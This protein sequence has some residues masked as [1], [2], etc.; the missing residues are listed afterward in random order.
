MN[1]IVTQSSA[2]ALE[3][4]L[5]GGDLSKLSVPDRVMY[6]KKVCE[7]VGLNPLTKPFEYITLNNKLTL[8]ARRDAT[9]QL[10]QI[11]KVSINIV[12]RELVEDCYVVTARATTSI[13]QDESIG[14]VNIAGLK[15][16]ARANAMMKAETKAKRRVTLSICGLGMLDE[17]EVETIPGAQ[18]T[19]TAGVLASLPSKI[20]DVV[21]ETAEQIKAFLANDQTQDAYALWQNSHFDAEQETALWSLLPSNARSMLKRVD[22]AAKATE[23]GTISQAQHRR[24]EKYIKDNGIDREKVKEYAKTLFGKEHF[25]ELTKDEYARLDGDLDRFL[26]SKSAP[27]QDAT[28]PGDPQ[29]ALPPVPAAGAPDIAP[30][31]N[32]NGD[33][34]ARESTQAGA[35]TEDEEL[36]T[37]AAETRILE[38]EN[39]LDI[40]GSVIKA[41]F[42]GFMAKE[43]WKS[44]AE[45]PEDR[46]KGAIKWING[47]IDK[48]NAREGAAT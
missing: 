29:P 39:A 9:D 22:D 4:V 15:G 31:D 14:A 1:D 37:D 28:S 27:A 3:S 5:I 10:R 16:D 2:T 20:Q 48:K 33:P 38:I 30:P 42:K 41:K 23:H 6:Y 13:R 46:F 43:G 32:G 26:P 44:Y 47:E 21:I 24:L 12:E 7:S 17:T 40:G 35:I 19:P 25:T 36:F 11:H 18:I 45:I 34:G 8:Y